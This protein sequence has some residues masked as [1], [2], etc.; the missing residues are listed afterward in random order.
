M[1][2]RSKAG[3]TASVIPADI[4]IYALGIGSTEGE[5]IPAK[6]GGWLKY[7]GRPVISRLNENRSEERRVGKECR[8]RGSAEHLKY[9]RWKNA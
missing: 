4:P 7:Q 1:L 6:N 5:A 8:S 2:F 3:I 9:N